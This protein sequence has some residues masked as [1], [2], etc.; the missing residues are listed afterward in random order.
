MLDELLAYV[1]ADGRVC[2]L[3]DKWNQLWERLPDRRRSGGGGEPPPP[4]I[5]GAWR[6]TPALLKWLRLEEHIRYADAHGALREVD[7]FLRGLDERE[8][9]HLGDF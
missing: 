9:A 3:P 2:P 8:W 7:A 6:E 1:R 5:L 4:L